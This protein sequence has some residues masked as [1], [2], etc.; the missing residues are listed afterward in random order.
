M[1]FLNPLN[2]AGSRCASLG[3]DEEGLLGSGHWAASAAFLVIGDTIFVVINA[4][5]F[6]VFGFLGFGPLADD[7]GERVQS[8]GG[9]ESE[10]LVCSR[11]ARLVFCARRIKEYKGNESPT[12]CYS[13]TGYATQYGSDNLPRT[14]R[15]PNSST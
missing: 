1:I 6:P 2:T 13:A 4:G 8:S 7:D 14:W 10:R 11:F 3:R 5:V 15:T 9:L 12:R